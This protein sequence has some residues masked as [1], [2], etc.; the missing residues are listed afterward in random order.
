[1]HAQVLGLGTL[2]KD[3]SGRLRMVAKE[4]KQ[5]LSA[6]AQKKMKLKGGMASGGMSTNGMASTLAFTPVQVRRMHTPCS[7]GSKLHHEVH[8]AWQAG[9]L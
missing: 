8:A 5:R 4:Q 1:M 3:G 6:K 9:P 7:G 2:G